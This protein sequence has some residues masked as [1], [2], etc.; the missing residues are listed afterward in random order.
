MSTTIW[1]EAEGCREHDHVGGPGTKERMASMVTSGASSLV[2]V[3]DPKSKV[4]R[5]LCHA[6]VAL[7]MALDSDSREVSDGQV[8]DSAA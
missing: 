3:L 4:Y 6:H 1:C 7:V 8:Q 2:Y 5:R